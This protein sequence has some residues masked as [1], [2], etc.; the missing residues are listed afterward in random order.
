MFVCSYLGTDLKNGTGSSIYFWETEYITSAL[1]EQSL[2]V[3]ENEI[4][5]VTIP[6]KDDERNILTGY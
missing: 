1:L 6:L 5:S 3:P 2:S 4:S